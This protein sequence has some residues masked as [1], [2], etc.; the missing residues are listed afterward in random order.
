MP[1]CTLSVLPSPSPER[2]LSMLNERL[3]DTG[4]STRYDAGFIIS[5]QQQSEEDGGNLEIRGE[6]M[7]P[8]GCSSEKSVCLSPA[9][10]DSARVAST[11]RTHRYK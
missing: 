6:I 5:R 7:Q 1:S 3:H 10:I 9:V 8:T 4:S 2:P 11:C